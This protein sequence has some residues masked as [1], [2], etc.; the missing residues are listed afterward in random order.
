[1][2]STGEN[3]TDLRKIMDMTRYGGIFILLL[4]FYYYCFAA[5]KMWGLTSKITD[6]LMFNISQTGLFKHMYTSKLIALGLL[7]ISLLGSQGRKDEKLHWK[8]ITA[9][10]CSGL[11]LY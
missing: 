11:T 10:V 3:E 8:P 1:M 6:R 4:N 2:S 7:L 9:L 5:F